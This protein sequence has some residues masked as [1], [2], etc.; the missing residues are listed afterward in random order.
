MPAYRTADGAEAVHGATNSADGRRLASGGTYTDE[1]GPGERK[2]YTVELDSSS[3]PRISAVALPEAG[4]DVSYSD[5]LTLTLESTDG[6]TCGEGTARFSADGAAWPLVAWAARVVG[7]DQDCQEAGVYNLSVARSGEKT[8]SGGDWPVELRLMREPGL[9]SRPAEVSRE[10]EDAPTAL[11]KMPTEKPRRIRGGTGFNDAAGMASGVWRDRIRPGETRFYRVPLDWGRSL[12]VRTEFATTDTTDTSG[13]TSQGVRTEVYSPARAFVAG[14][15]ALY[16][17]DDPA[18]VP[19]RTPRVTYG[20]RYSYQDGLAAASVAG[21]YY[22]AVHAHRD[23]GDFVTDAVP[24]TLRVRLSGKATGGPDYD[25]DPAAAGFGVTG[26]DREQAD[27]GQTPQAA[28]RSE[29]LTVVGWSGIGAGA[30]LV[31]VLALWAVLARRR[32]ARAAPAAPAGG[33]S[34]AGYAQQSTQTASSAPYGGP[35]YAS[36]PLHGPPANGS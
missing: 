13:Y 32:A 2:Y 5:S 33:G 16:G 7:P 21:W 9:A 27:R 3:Q 31:A 34:G 25:G 36:G 23:L 24:V 10:A 1:V 30:G 19:L 18:A 26:E 11:P 4:A 14:D 6:T 8:D 22:V 29:L 12:A 20:S 15:S 35:P 28:R 17:A